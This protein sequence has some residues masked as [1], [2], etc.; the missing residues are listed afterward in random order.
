[1]KKIVSSL[2]MVTS[3]IFMTNCSNT[4]SAAS[5]SSASEALSQN[6]WKLIEVLGAKVPSSSQAGLLFSPGTVNKVS[7]STGCNRMTGT[8]ETG[9]NNSIKFPPLATTRM[10]CLD[11]GVNG[12]EGKF[13]EALSKATS[14]EISGNELLLKNGS[15]ALATLKPLMR[16]S[17]E[18]V[19]LN[20]TL[21]LNYISGSQIA[22]EGLFP[23]KKPT[24]IFNL[25]GT[26]VN[27]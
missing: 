15:A 27:G 1:M 18:D 4:R 23:N 8:Y 20:G 11:E 13:L 16:S 25:P 26:E 3:V 9:T 14:W 10:A 6:E 12:I 2:A 24:I 19:R 22:F 21:E 7:G 17:T 5:T